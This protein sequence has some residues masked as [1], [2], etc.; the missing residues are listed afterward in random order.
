ME[1]AGIVFMMGPL[2]ITRTVVTTWGIMVALTLLSLVLTHRLQEKEN[3]LRTLLESIVTAM[4]NAVKEVVPQHAAAVFPFIAS[5]W[6]FLVVANLLGIVPGLHGPTGDLSTTAALASIVFVS[7]HAYGIRFQG[8][9]PYLKHYLAPSPILLPFHLLSEITRSLALTIRL[10]G[11]IMSLEMAA[12]LVLMV[13]GFL[14]PVPLLALHIIEALVQA[15]IFGVLA[16]L[17]IAGALESQTTSP[18]SEAQS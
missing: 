2:G 6:V 8:L 5:L 18:S 12:L 11:N 4:D 10:F 3:L 1:D 16:L 9:R 15:Y 7:V 14:V 13:A 17:Y